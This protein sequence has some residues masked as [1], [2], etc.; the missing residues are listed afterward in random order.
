MFKNRVRL[1]F[2]ITRPQFP[3]ELNSFRLA[4]GTVR[5]ESAIVR[6]VYEG[7]TDYLPEWIHERLQIALSH[8][9]VQIEGDRYLGGVAAEGEY[10]I[11][12][13]EHLDYPLGTG[14]FKVQVTPF[15][16]SN[17]NCQSCEEATQIELEDDTFGAPVAEDMEY[18]IDLFANDMIGCLPY[19]VTVVYFNTDFLLS[20]IVDNDGILTI[21]TK[22]TFQEANNAKI[23]TYRVTCPNGGYDEA[24]VYGN[25]AGSI[26]ACQAPT[27]LAA[28][29]IDEFSATISWTP[30]VDPPDDGF[31]WTLA[32]ADSPAVILD[33]GTTT[34]APVELP[35]N[36][37]SLMPG[38]T[39]IFSIR[40]RCGEIYGPY[41]VYQFTTPATSGT[42]GKYIVTVF[43][44]GGQPFKNISYIS[45]GGNQVTAPMFLFRSRLLCVL[46][47]APNMPVSIIGADHI[48]YQGLCD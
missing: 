32:E 23:A 41:T 25:M 1:P 40:G 30:P 19:E 38:V 45:C 31:E 2:Y 28:I 35:S 11:E 16:A 12:W 10:E 24:D 22:T 14:T 13:P 9:E 36:G 47:T 21:I 15:N 7:K 48:S 8:D 42:C 34:D 5:T 29:D 27:G 4:D 33:S 46:Q 43:S 20:A 39:Y 18:Q 37:D 3:R 6:K 26:P 44:S 17:A